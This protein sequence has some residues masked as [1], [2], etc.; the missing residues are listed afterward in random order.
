M[1]KYSYIVPDLFYCGC[2]FIKLRATKI[3]SIHMFIFIA[4]VTIVGFNSWYYFMIVILCD[5][6]LLDQP[7]QGIKLIVDLSI[8]Y[9]LKFRCGT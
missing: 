3:I 2:Y 6:L 4:K 5:K 7:V 1:L 9:A 8:A